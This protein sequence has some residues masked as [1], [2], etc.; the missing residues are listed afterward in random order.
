MNSKLRAILTPEQRETFDQMIA[1]RTPGREESRPATVYVLED[2]QP[3][4][5]SV[6]V[7][8]ADDQS[9]EVVSGLQEGDA[10]IVRATRK[11]G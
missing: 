4:L 3:R 7:G 8:L 6:R 11:Q 9:T 5:V 1:G 2:D 10:I